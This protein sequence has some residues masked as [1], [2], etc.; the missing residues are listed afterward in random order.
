[1]GYSE[2]LEAAG[3]EV[4]AFREFGS[5]QGDWFAKVAYQGRE[6]WVHG[7]YGSCSGCDAFLA[8]F[9]FDGREECEEHRWYYPKETV[10]SCTAC[11]EKKADYDRRMVEFGKGYLTSGEMTQEEALKYASEHLEW[12]SEAQEMVDFIGGFIKGE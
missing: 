4:K 12:D 6:F 8:E 7:S 1:M 11:A 9:D 5:Y 10:V 3:A 2:A